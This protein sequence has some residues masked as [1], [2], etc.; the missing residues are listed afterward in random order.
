MIDFMLLS[1][2]ILQFKKRSY[3][4]LVHTDH[5]SLIAFWIVIALVCSIFSD[6]SC[7]V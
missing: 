6:A 7:L 3:S 5:V 2:S 1:Y 4:I